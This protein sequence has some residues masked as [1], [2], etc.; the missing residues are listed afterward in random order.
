MLGVMIVRVVLSLLTK[1]LPQPRIHVH[2]GF[3]V[4]RQL[5][6]FVVAVFAK[7]ENPTSHNTRIGIIQVDFVFPA[8]HTVPGRPKIVQPANVAAKDAR[9][10]VEGYVS[11]GY[12]G[13]NGHAIVQGWPLARGG[14]FVGNVAFW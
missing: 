10:G 6:A 14:V 9:G 11:K 4:A 2:E 3:A 1:D 8:H 7:G 13:W 12:T 5:F